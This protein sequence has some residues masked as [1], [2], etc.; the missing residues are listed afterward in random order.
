MFSF[1]VYP[2]PLYPP[3]YK[4]W[5][6]QKKI[7]LLASLADCTPHF[8][9]CGAA[10]DSNFGVQSDEIVPKTLREPAEGRAIP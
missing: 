6:V 9:I 1:Q 8:Q 10:L 2:P 7:F 3:L 4:K 5:G